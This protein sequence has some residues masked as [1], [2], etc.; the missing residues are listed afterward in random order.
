MHGGRAK[1]MLL[2]V[3]SVPTMDN[4]RQ[5]YPLFNESLP[6]VAAA[7]AAAA[8]AVMAAWRGVVWCGVVWYRSVGAVYMTG[9]ERGPEAVSMLQQGM[10]KGVNLLAVA[11]CNYE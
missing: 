7:A 8:A 1:M 3:V 4:Q 9:S 10:L 2:A 6:P 5:T 11:D